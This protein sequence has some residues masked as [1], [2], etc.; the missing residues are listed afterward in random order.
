MH[1][2]T[3]LPRDASTA[4]K[5]TRAELEQPD[6]NAD[7]D[8]FAGC[9]ASGAQ[10]ASVHSLK[11]T[12]L[13][14]ARLVAHE[15]IA[16]STFFSCDDDFDVH[17]TPRPHHA[18][19]AFPR[20]PS[21][22]DTMDTARDPPFL[23]A[24]L[25]TDNLTLPTRIVLLANHLVETCF[26][27]HNF[28][29]TNTKLFSITH[30]VLDRVAELDASAE[31][32][33][34]GETL[35]SCDAVNDA[36]EIA[37]MLMETLRS[38]KPV[39]DPKFHGALKGILTLNNTSDAILPGAKVPVPSDFIIKLFRYILIMMDSESRQILHYLV[40]FFRKIC[41]NSKSKIP[42]TTT[43]REI[44]K[45]FGPILVG[46][47]AVRPASNGGGGGRSN[48]SSVAWS[49][50]LCEF[51]VYAHGLPG[52]D[53]SSGAVVASSTPLGANAGSSAVGARKV[54]V[55]T[56]PSNLWKIPASLQETINERVNVQRT[57]SRR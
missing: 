45:A 10:L 13:V 43:V 27:K 49:E 21:A 24:T 28:Q 30:I 53:V 37:H 26:M 4:R 17:A 3:L 31:S 2:E 25:H 36:P 20:A 33:G 50:T 34:M 18:Q 56:K 55:R 23:T 15:R 38:R 39:F 42:M 44:S 12:S 9:A 47:E 6:D 29:T 8:V 16:K 19:L 7:D 1:A 48:A 32:V 41:V 46:F 14:V 52:Q 5:R 54:H 57:P 11:D 51:L 22:L 35:R 40:D